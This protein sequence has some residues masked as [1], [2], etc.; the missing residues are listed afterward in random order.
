M[1]FE[2]SIQNWVSLDNQIRTLSER[3]KALRTERNDVG[4][5]IMAYVET[6]ELNNA[7]VKISDGKLRF[8]V[9][10]QTAPLT[11]RHVEDCLGKCIN[12]TSKVSAIMNYIKS[13]R[14]IRENS[15]IKRSYAKEQQ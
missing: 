2:S 5:N 4:D 7:V 1:S 15:D 6:N 13:T 8:G 3:V 10:R 12:D 9:T 14:D 11:L